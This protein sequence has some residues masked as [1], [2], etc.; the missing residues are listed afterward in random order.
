MKSNFLYSGIFFR[1][2]DQELLKHWWETNVGPLYDNVYCHHM[3]I[4]FKP[5]LSEVDRLPFGL[6]P[7][8]VVGCAQDDF[9]QTFVVETKAKSDNKFKHIT[10]ATKNGTK[11]Y[12]SNVLLEKGFSKI[13]GPKLQGCVG[14]VLDGRE[15]YHIPR[16]NKEQ[17]Y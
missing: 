17:T 8:K 5:T 2:V 12:Y 9:C 16:W 13:D 7:V 10:V 4:K 1:D 11:P 14:Y 3:T 6:M 15:C